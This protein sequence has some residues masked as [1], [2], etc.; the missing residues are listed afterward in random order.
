MTKALFPLKVWFQNR[1]AKWRKREK[2]GV[3]SHTLSLH[4]PGT[5][6]AAQS[7]CHYL[8]RNPFVLNPHPAIDSSWP[9]PF[10]RLAQPP[11][12]PASPHGFSA[13]LGAAMFRHPAFINPTFGRWAS[14]AC[15]TQ[16][17]KFIPYLS[18]FIMVI[19]FCYISQTFYKLRSNG[20][21]KDTPSYHRGSNSTLPPHQQPSLLFTTLTFIPNSG[22]PRFQHSSTASQSK[23][24][25]CSA[26]SH[27]SCWNGWKR[28]VLRLTLTW[29]MAK[30]QSQA[31]ALIVSGE[32][33]DY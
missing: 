27:H 16:T 26:D 15:S 5:P 28:G 2:T 4:Y 19:I 9:A 3:Q 32:L 23:G 7:L 21:A 30:D 24:A 6:P 33:G 10:Q 17:I 12:N 11:L 22:P 29:E 18:H 14:S 1:R 25:F 13:L 31:E 20:T 8:S